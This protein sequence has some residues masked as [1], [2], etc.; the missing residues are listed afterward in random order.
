MSKVRGLITLILC[1]TLLFAFTTTAFA[2]ADPESPEITVVP[3]D[4]SV[5]DTG[6]ENGEGFPDEGNAYTHNPLYD[7]NTNK[8]FLVVQTK[9]G[10]TFYIIIDYDK[11][12]DDEE[13]LYQTYFLNMVD[14]RDL[15]DLMDEEDRETPAPVCTCR[16]RCAPGKVEMNCPVCKTDMAACMGTDP[17]PDTTE[18]PEPT[19]PPEE[20]AEKKSGGSVGIVLVMILLIA[21]A[22]GGYYYFKFIRGKKQ[23]DEDL[24]FYDDEGYEEEYVNE[25]EPD[26]ES[27]NDGYDEYD[28]GD[29]EDDEPDIETDE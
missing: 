9:N 21:G 11:Q 17:V 15:F 6:P 12:I 22:G 3:E 8:Q 14:E 2:Y 16:E 1:L 19:E 5:A 23:K 28:G 20:P 24:D 13:E 18:E 10:N 25:D 27:D 7:K 26:A 4:T 29:Y